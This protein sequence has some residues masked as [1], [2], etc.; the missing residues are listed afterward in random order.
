MDY[1]SVYLMVKWEIAPGSSRFSL[2]FGEAFP[3]VLT[4]EA[5]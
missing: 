4:G 1:M 3:G 2:T 5:G